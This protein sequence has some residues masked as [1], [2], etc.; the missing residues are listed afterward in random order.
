MQLNMQAE[1]V[2]ILQKLLLPKGD[3]AREIDR[4]FD[5]KAALKS[6]DANEVVRTNAKR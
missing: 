1:Q 5:P 4:W 2:M 6:I 3:A